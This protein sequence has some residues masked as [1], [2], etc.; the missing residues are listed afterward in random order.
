[1]WEFHF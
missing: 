1:M